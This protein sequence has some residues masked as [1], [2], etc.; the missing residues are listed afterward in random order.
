MDLDF[1][2]PLYDGTGGYVSVYLDTSR[3]HE[4]AAHEIEVRWRDARERLASAGA[5]AATLDALG[6][7][8]ADPEPATPGR[9]AFGRGGRL[10]LTEGDRKSVV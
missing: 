7:A 6:A 4:N 2:R 10:L 3:D 5:D 8:F 9:A 1:L